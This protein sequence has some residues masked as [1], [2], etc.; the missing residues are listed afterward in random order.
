MKISK[1]TAKH[2]CQK[3][4]TDKFV[5][6]SHFGV[7]ISKLPVIYIVQNIK[8]ECEISKLFVENEKLDF[9]LKNLV[10]EQMIK[11]P[12]KYRCELTELENIFHIPFFCNYTSYINLI[13]ASFTYNSKHLW[14]VFCYTNNFQIYLRHFGRT[15]L[16]KFHIY[17]IYVDVDVEFS[18]EKTIQKYY[19]I[20]EI[21][22]L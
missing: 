16:K 18:L 10:E 8:V 9:F 3:N 15:W 4:M 11:L 1:C 7:S 19:Y 21:F 12:P 2:C 14:N 6:F 20:S 5:F 13:L 17:I 22:Y